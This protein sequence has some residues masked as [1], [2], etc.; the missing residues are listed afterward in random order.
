MLDELE[1]GSAPVRHLDDLLDCEAGVLGKLMAEFR[2]LKD[3]QN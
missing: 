1:P 2:K 3:L